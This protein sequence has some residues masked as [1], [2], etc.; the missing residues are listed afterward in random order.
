MPFAAVHEFRIWH[1]KRTSRD[2]CYFSAFGCKADIR[3]AYNRDLRVHALAGRQR[4]LKLSFGH[5][6]LAQGLDPTRHE[7]KR[8]IRNPQGEAPAPWP[9]SPHAKVKQIARPRGHAHAEGPTPT[10]PSLGCSPRYG[11]VSAQPAL[12][13]SH[14]E[15][16]WMRSELRA[17]LD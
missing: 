2:V 10:K 17:C 11:N 8:G 16:L 3:I 1:T 15:R 4:P 14:G 9:R 5:M 13:R 6:R 7:A 12:R